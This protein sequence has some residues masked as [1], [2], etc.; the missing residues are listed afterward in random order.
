MDTVTERG[1]ISNPHSREN[2]AEYKIGALEKLFRDL[3]FRT[4][5]DNYMMDQDNLAAQWDSQNQSLSYEENYNSAQAAAERMR[6]A[7]INPDLQGIENAGDAAEMAEN[8]LPPSS[9]MNEL[10]FAGNGAAKLG[11]TLLGLLTDGAS[12]VLTAAGQTVD[13]MTKYEGYEQNKIQT[14]IQDATLSKQFTELIPELQR[15]YNEVMPDAQPGEL[16]AAIKTD[17]AAKFWSK[18]LGMSKRNSKRLL[19]MWNYI[20]DTTPARVTRSKDKLSEKQ[21]NYQS[22]LIDQTKAVQEVTNQNLI[23]RAEIDAK[24]LKAEAELYEKYP[25]IPKEIIQGQKSLEIASNIAGINIAS[26]KSAAAAY[27]KLQ[28]T[29]LKEIAELDFKAIQEYEQ[30]LRESPLHLNLDPNAWSEYRKAMDR[31]YGKRGDYI[32]QLE[33]D[34]QAVGGLIF[35]K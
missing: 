8:E 18:K 2:R 20:L 1:Q 16:K 33:E 27:Q 29:K 24:Y 11:L 34:A 15:Y 25:N 4:G 6:E 12:N 31:I 35:K 19:D 30:K 32:G 13:L 28:S 14:D 3:G 22:W 23:S 26:A 10:E 5:Y 21:T 9:G 17:A 7:G